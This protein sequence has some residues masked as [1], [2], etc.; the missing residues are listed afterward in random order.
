MKVRLRLRLKSVKDKVLPVVVQSSAR[1]ALGPG[2]DLEE[3]WKKNRRQSAENAL[4]NES[5]IRRLSREGLTV[6]ELARIFRTSRSLVVCVCRNG[7][8]KWACEKY[9]DEGVWFSPRRDPNAIELSV[10]KLDH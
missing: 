5:E 8:L 7:D 1:G 10:P 9:I 2:A 3:Q 4:A 6:T